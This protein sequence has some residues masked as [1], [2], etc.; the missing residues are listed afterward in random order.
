[1]PRRWPAVKLEAWDGGRRHH[2]TATSPHPRKR[3]RVDK[4]RGQKKGRHA[5][6][7]PVREIAREEIANLS[8]FVVAALPMVQWAPIRP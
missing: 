7:R 3:G 5:S 8:S 6:W 1:M 2:G 4:R